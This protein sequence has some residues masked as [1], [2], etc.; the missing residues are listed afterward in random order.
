MGYHPR[1]ESKETASF[2]TTRS[3]NSELWFVNNRRLEE[4]VMGHVARVST[5]YGVKIYALAL[6]GNHVQ[7]PALFPQGNRACFMRDLN[8]AIARSV[9]RLVPEYTGGRLWAR[10]YSGE[11]LPGG[12]DI[13]ERFF[14]TVLQP[15]Q[16]GLVEKI[17][18]YPGY[19]CFHDAVYGIK[20]KFK[21]IRWGAFNAAKRYNPRVK[22]SDYTEIVYLS[23]ERLPGYE[24]L[25][26]AEYAKLMHKK[27]ADRTEE[28]VKKHK[29]Q[30]LGYVGREALLRVK[31]GSLPKSTKT[32]DRYSHRPRV[33]SVCPKRRAECLAWYF[34]IYFAYKAASFSYRKGDLN[35]TF[36]PGTYRPYCAVM[37]CSS[38]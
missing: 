31:P 4:S 37:Q 5:R 21:V 32:S 22:I 8:S 16:D 26:Q 17:S 9:A 36:P 24:E 30:G 12:P 19:N 13:E 11:F 20:R 1:I 29:A 33:L 23:Y 10:R 3:R 25:S 38:P 7:A 14:Y 35:V 6:E 34:D 2:L 15:V 18:E 27:L 28:L